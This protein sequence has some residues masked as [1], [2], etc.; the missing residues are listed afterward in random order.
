MQLW[1][2]HSQLLIAIQ[3]NDLDAAEDILKQESFDPDVRFAF[4]SGNQIPAICLCVERGLYQMAKLLI[5][6]KC[7]INQVDDCG[8]TPL[9]FA[10]S[11]Q[12]YDLLTLLINH[13]ANVNAVSNYG[14][15]PLHLASQQSSVGKPFRFSIVMLFLMNTS[16]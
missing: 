14:H 12:F 6:Y 1:T 4:G 3:D 10:A 15:T 16:I 5:D 9:H 11:H 2:L 7:S 8:Y 13:R